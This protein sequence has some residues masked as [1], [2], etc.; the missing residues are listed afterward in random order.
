MTPIENRLME[1]AFRDIPEGIKALIL[2]QFED[3][4]VLYDAGTFNWQHYVDEDVRQLWGKLDFSQKLIA[5]IHAYSRAS[6]VD[7]PD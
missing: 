7:D 2:E 6:D 3:S 5:F 1:I 4:P